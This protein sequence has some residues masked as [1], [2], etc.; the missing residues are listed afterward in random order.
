M[1]KTDI[2]KEDMLKTVSGVNVKTLERGGI[3]VILN[4]EYLNAMF[5]A[6]LKTMSIEAFAVIV[7]RLVKNG[8]RNYESLKSDMMALEMFDKAQEI[9]R[10]E[11]TRLDVIT[12]QAEGRYQKEFYKNKFITDAFVSQKTAQIKQISDCRWGS[13]ESVDFDGSFGGATYKNRL[14]VESLSDCT[15]FDAS[16]GPCTSLG[17]IFKAIKVHPEF[18]EH[19]KKIRFGYITTD[20]KY[21]RLFGS[22]FIDFEMDQEGQQ[23]LTDS[24]NSLSEAMTSFY[25]TTTYYGD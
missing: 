5:G 13:L 24:Q 14:N 23:L 2:T 7:Q 21:L 8:L 20:S 4:D 15:N 22:A 1:I 3:E 11:Q 16:F 12:K 9:V 25:T 18:V 10:T 6:D 19:I 17:I